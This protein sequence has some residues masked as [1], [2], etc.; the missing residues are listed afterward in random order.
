MKKIW[1]I[2]YYLFARHLP[3]YTMFYAFGMYKFRYFVAKQ[4]FEKC[5]K[6]VKIGKGALIGS[7]KNISIGSDSSIGKDCIVSYAQIGENVMMGE[8]VVFYAANHIYK[9]LN[10]PMSHQGMVQPRTIVIEDDVWLGAFSIILPSC[11]SI[12]QGAIIAAGSVVTK[13]VPPLAIVG[14]NPAKILKYR[15]E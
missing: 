9:D 5:G 10:I 13:D 6:R 4:M 3:H 8:R 7:G 11:K 14:G 2:I 12:G 1:G 15:D